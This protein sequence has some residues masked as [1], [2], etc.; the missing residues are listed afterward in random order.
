MVS[1]DSAIAALCCTCPE[2][3]R[4]QF[5]RVYISWFK[6]AWQYIFTAKLLACMKLYNFSELAKSCCWEVSVIDVSVV[7]Y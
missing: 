2:N 4:K 5:V 6:R 7:E 3:Y 1:Y